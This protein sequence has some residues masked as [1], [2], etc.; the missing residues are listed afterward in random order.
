[1]R[2]IEVKIYNID[3]LSDKAQQRAFHDW[4]SDDMYAW[5]CENEKTLDEFISIFPVKVTNWQYGY[6]NYINFYMTCDDD[7]EELEGFRLAKHLWNEYKGYI[8]KGKYYSTG[9]RWI[10]GKYHYKHRYSKITLER[11]CVLTGYCIDDDIL[12]PLYDFLDRPVEGVTFKELM[13]DCLDAWIKACADDYEACRSFEY[14]KEDSEINNYEYY[15]NGRV[16]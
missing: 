8:Y 6:G 12:K 5:S 1:M 14:F 9:Q 4:L 13:E 16:A 11:S 10:D 15:E 2:T 7:L 3:E